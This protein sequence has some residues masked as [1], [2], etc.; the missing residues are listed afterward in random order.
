MFKKMFCLVVLSLIVGTA[1]AGESV[2]YFLADNVEITSARSA[3]GL[4]YVALEYD[5]PCWARFVEVGSVTDV[6]GSR[7]NPAADFKVALSVVLKEKGA[8]HICT[9]EELAVSR[10]PAGITVNTNAV[11]GKFLGLEIVQ[12]RQPKG[13]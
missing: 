5:R 1:Y 8:S 13:R 4:T 6:L 10:N 11:E 7:V 9:H 12:A 2:K 3:D